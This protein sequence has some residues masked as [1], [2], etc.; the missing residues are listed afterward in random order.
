MYIADYF[1]PVPKTANKEGPLSMKKGLFLLAGCIFIAS[2]TLNVIYLGKSYSFRKHEKKIAKAREQKR[3]ANLQ[4]SKI[5][6]Q[7]K[8]TGFYFREAYFD[9]WRDAAV[10]IF[11]K[12][13]LVQKE[14]LSKALSITP[15]L[16]L[17]PDT[18]VM[19][20]RVVLKGNFLPGKTYLFRLDPALLKTEEKMVLAMPAVFSIKIPPKRPSL[21]FLTQGPYLPLKKGGTSLPYAATN[22]KKLR[23]EIRKNYNN[24]PDSFKYTTENSSRLVH[25]HSL[26]LSLPENKET[27]HDLDLSFLKEKYGPGLYDI[28]ISSLDPVTSYG[29]DYAE[30]IKIIF[31]DLAISCAMPE[32]A[33][34]GAKGAVFVH[35]LDSN[36]PCPGATV[37]LMSRKQQIFAKGITDRDGKCTLNI[38]RK[39]EDKDDAPDKIIVKK[40]GD[41]A[42]LSLTSKRHDLSRFE[43]PARA[44][45]H[46]PEVFLYTQRGICRPGEIIHAGLFA[47]KESNG[48]NLPLAKTLL[49][50]S[51]T[52]PAGT[53]LPAKSVTTDEYGFA[54]F[55]FSIPLDARTGV[56]LLTANEPGGDPEN[57]N[58]MGSCRFQVGE[59]VADRIKASL[60][61]KG[62]PVLVKSTDIITFH[63][64]AK[65]YFGAPLSADTRGTLQVYPAKLPQLPQHWKGYQVGDTDTPLQSGKTFF[66]KFP[67]SAKDIVYQGFSACDGKSSLPVLLTGVFTVAEPGGRAVSSHKSIVCSVMDTYFGIRQK[68]DQKGMKQFF[69]WKL[70]AMDEKTS[71]PAKER[72]YTWELIRL[73]WDCLLKEKNGKYSYEWVQKSIP[74]LKK[75][76]TSSAVSGSFELPEKLDAGEY[77]LLVT[78]GKMRTKHT[79]WHNEGSAGKRSSN[80]SILSLTTN[81]QKY[82]PGETALLSFHSPGKGS[83]QIV[84]GRKDTFRIKNIPVLAGKNMVR[85]KIPENIS[86][87]LYHVSFTLVTGKKGNIRR[88][89]ALAL[90]HVDLSLSRKLIPG[91][92]HP[93]RA[94]PGKEITIQISLRSPATGKGVPGMVHLFGCDAGVLSL[95][96][97]KTPDIYEF[98]SGKRLSSLFFTDMYDKLFP[99][100]ALSSNGKFGG[101]AFSAARKDLLG[102]FQLKVKAP[103][104]ISLG[105]VKIGK[106]GKGSVKV[107][108]PDFTGNLVL[109]AVAAN[110]TRTG[111]CESNLLIRDKITATANLPRAVA[112]GDEFI[113]SFTL[114]NLDADSGDFSFALSLPENWKCLSSPD[115]TGKLA[116]KGQT[117]GT[118]LLKAPEKAGIYP[119]NYS[120]TLRSGKEVIQKKGSTEIVVRHTIPSV[121]ESSFHLVQPGQTLT[122]A[123]EKEKWYSDGL[124]KVVT[125]NTSPL[126]LLADSLDFLHSYPYGC[127][128]QTAAGA[129]PMLSAD[130][131]Y[132]CN[133]IGKEQA[134]TAGYTV[135]QAAY[136]ILSMLRYDG[137]FSMWPGADTP[138]QAGTLFA[139]HFLFEA[140]EKG[141]FIIPITAR[142][143]ICRN[144]YRTADDAALS[145]GERAYA[146]C[147]LAISGSSRFRNIARNLLMENKQDLA[148]F[149]AA[150]AMIRGGYAAEGMLYMKEALKKELWKEEGVPYIY[151]DKSVRLGMI[152]YLLSRT[153]AKDPACLKLL[154]ELQKSLRKDGSGWGTTH[155]NAWITMGI[156][157]FAEA[158]RLSMEQTKEKSPGFLLDHDGKK[159]P[160]ASGKSLVKEL[161]AAEEIKIVLSETSSPVFVTV[162]SRGILRKGQAKAQGL[163]VRREYRN[164]KGEKITSAAHGDLVTVR[165]I[166]NAKEDMKDVVISDLLPGGLEIEDGSLATREKR[167]QPVRRHGI[168]VNFK[169]NRFDR[170]LLFCDLN[171]GEEI[172]EYKARAVIR[173]KYHSGAISA[174]KM[175]DPDTTALAVPEDIFE[176]K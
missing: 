55:S 68:S 164:D 99:D 38:T 72:K 134:D 109:S 89:F 35:S 31:T 135:N 90:L 11:S 102:P 19:A 144:L 111:S 95:T 50:I 121:A 70:L 8:E 42:Y 174:E 40:N 66:R 1:P 151:A 93:P 61:V 149:F 155:A 32:N 166:T 108:L 15:A 145:R 170:F 125:V 86:S 142:N 79:F 156:S 172:Y 147:I 104:M 106:N 84:C 34:N 17:S 37:T 58:T 71:I 97:W 26:P 150:Y 33:V 81:K 117:N 43:S 78:S 120:F 153:N 39:Y 105:K 143:L 94:L 67:L 141:V 30:S 25:E 100:L 64:A 75:E 124:K 77:V 96:N 14:T 98:F 130:L 54:R 175:Y 107:K 160:L 74:V 101:G 41:I 83:V 48:K 44:F 4:K 163:T 128:E 22:I 127:L 119:V 57:K 115:I 87:S 161:K 113:S 73:Q 21:R 122:I 59:Y 24:H 80:L 165:I 20:G 171:K 133:V 131:L 168:K 91:L 16:P 45:S 162:R 167:I 65:Y 146:A 63:P 132:K 18:R 47:R 158:H 6:Q 103:A 176:V 29:W 148:S 27:F 46:A 110:Q 88:S 3:S 152:L 126:A 5:T 154:A 56:W 23:L 7:K 82:V 12:D 9:S 49:S 13:V 112:P 138:F 136:R 157:A 159:I 69:Q 114:F 52:D 173:G 10:V 118:F 51:L 92:T 116:K 139:S 85:I 53:L 76:I 36:L 123:K 169:E 60:R 129:F 137:S 28:K 2:I 140:E 62:D